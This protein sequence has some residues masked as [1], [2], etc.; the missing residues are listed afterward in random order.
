[1]VVAIIGIIVALLSLVVSPGV[2]LLVIAVAI[3]G[4]A[5]LIP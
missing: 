1:M 4:A 5:K 2:P 3:I